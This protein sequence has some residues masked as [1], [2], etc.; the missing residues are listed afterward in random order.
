MVIPIPISRHQTPSCLALKGLIVGIREGL[1]DPVLGPEQCVF[2]L[3]GDFASPV[4]N[5]AECYFGLYPCH[6]LCPWCQIYGSFFIPHLTCCYNS[7]T[8]GCPLC[9][10]AIWLPSSITPHL[11]EF[12]LWLF[13]SFF[14]LIFKFWVSSWHTLILLTIYLP[15][16]IY[17]TATFP[18]IHSYNI[19]E[20]II[21]KLY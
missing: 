12:H 11:S 4:A 9:L 5:Y 10:E 18:L 14:F 20:M 7:V 8:S 21:Y 15:F 1:L 3:T 19:H 17:I 16:I 6:Q 13:S 2:W